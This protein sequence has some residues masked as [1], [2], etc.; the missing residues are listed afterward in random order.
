MNKELLKF[1][2]ALLLFGS[3]GIIA[4]QVAL[5]SYSIVVLRT[6][7]GAMLL[8]VLFFAGF[9]KKGGSLADLAVVSQ[10]RSALLVAASGII[11]G[12][13]W[14]LLFRAYELVGVGVSSLLYYCGPVIVMALSPVL[15]S[16]RI[17]AARLAGFGAVLAGIVLV[18]G[19]AVDG[20]L[21]VEG[22]ACGAGSAAC[23]AAMIVFNKKAEGIGGTEKSFIQLFAAFATAALATALLHGLQFDLAG[24]N[25]PAV[26]VLGLA[27]TGLGCYLYFSSIGNLSV[28][29]VSA[30]G[31]LEPVSAVL[32]AAAFLGEALAPLQ[33]AG[34]VL[35]VA[36]AAFGELWSSALGTRHAIRPCPSGRDGHLR[37]AGVQPNR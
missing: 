12:L 24:L 8:G 18:N 28:Q 17:T 36:G 19:T 27:N 31:Y 33:L 29:T 34:A 23:L 30:L 32:F 14:M 6:L 15:F 25:W 22:L 20:G 10:K 37:A 7:L 3:N 16:E 2:A 9:A 21:N 1:I 4:S 35:V 13:A 26:L 5:P 11:L